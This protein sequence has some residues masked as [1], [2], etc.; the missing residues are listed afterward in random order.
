MTVAP[1]VGNVAMFR[2]M[3]LDQLSGV[4]VPSHTCTP[5]SPPASAAEFPLKKKNKIKIKRSQDTCVTSI[6]E[7]LL[8]PSD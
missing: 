2:L 1:V 4:T 5:L 6:S 7:V 3:H 8:D